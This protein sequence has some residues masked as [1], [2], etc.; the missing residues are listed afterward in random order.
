MTFDIKPPL[1]HDLV[2]LHGKWLPDKPALI[3]ERQT[4][5]WSQLDQRSNQVANGLRSLNIG[6]GDSVALLMS[7]SAEYVELIYGVLKAGAVVV[8]LNVAVREDG[9]VNMIQD[10]NS[11]IVFL[12]PE[13]YD[14]LAPL[15]KHLP[16]AIHLFVFGVSGSVSGAGDYES[17]RNAQQ[18]TDPGIEIGEDDPCNIIYSSGTTG[19]PKGIKHLYRRRVQS[20]YELS[21]AHRYHFEAVS[22]CPI[23]LYSNIS[24]GNLFCALIVGGTCVIQNKFDAASWLETVER[25]QVTHTFMVPIQFQRVLDHAS[26]RPETVSSLQAVISGGAPLYE[27][28]KK[29]VAENFPGCAVIELYGL[30]E[31]FMTT[32]Q[33]G[34]SAGR[35]TSVGKPVR[36]HDMILV[37]DDEREVGWGNT[38]EICVRSVHWM[39]GY[40][41]RPDATAEAEYIDANGVQWLRTGDIGR[42]DE[43]GFL[44]ITDRKK[45][46][47][48]SGGQ[49]IYP[50]DLESILI[51]HPMISE[52]AVIGIPDETWGETPIAIV[53]PAPSVAG[54]PDVAAEILAWANVHLGKRQRIKRVELL[55]DLPRNP[56]G[57]V[58]K[59]DLRETFG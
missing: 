51:E 32:L 24:W 3:D 38:G 14:R 44:Y 29:R 12:T 48:L 50:V 5:T 21:L 47:I 31:G 7:N 59:R 8:P 46:M 15:T 19:L 45:D 17:W 23:G 54:Q 18:A 9:L 25:Y 49:N 16:K 36:G 57:K 42:T 56:N 55:P 13:Q 35:L 22:I 4:V 28:L 43:Y 11:Q 10:S 34:E 39:I 33:P 6:R 52:V 30:T 37:D 58:L 2:R 41:N 53:V 1:F 20:M 26:F 27:S 40:H